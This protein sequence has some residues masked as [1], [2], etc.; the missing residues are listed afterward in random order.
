MRKEIILVSFTFLTLAISCQ[1]S[2]DCKT[3]K[4]Y[5]D[6]NII[7][8]YK[9][10]L[11]DIRPLSKEPF[12]SDWGPPIKTYK[13]TGDYLNN[14]GDHMTKGIFTVDNQKC[15]IKE[16]ND[17]EAIGDTVLLEISYLDDQYLLLTKINDSPYTYFYKR[18]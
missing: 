15:L 8:Y 14:Q 3:D 17:T 12:K 4:L 13:K 6:W 7:N 11:T 1:S 9:G 18:K 16:F 10:K 2:R 5:G